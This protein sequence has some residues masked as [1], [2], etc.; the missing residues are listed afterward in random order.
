V[1]PLTLGLIAVVAIIL[2]MS[3]IE[4]AAE[5]LQSCVTTIL[6]IVLIVVFAN[7]IKCG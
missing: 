7:M 4:F 1:D 3:I 6:V 5:M 2:F